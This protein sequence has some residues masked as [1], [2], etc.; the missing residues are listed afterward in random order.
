MALVSSIETVFIFIVSCV[1]S[2][3]ALYC[4]VTAIK[5]FWIHF[6]NR[7]GVFGSDLHMLRYFLQSNKKPYIFV[8]YKIDDSLPWE[9]VILHLKTTLD[10]L[11]AKEN[12]PLGV[13]IDVDKRCWRYQQ[14]GQMDSILEYHTNASDYHSTLDK[15]SRD[16]VFRVYSAGRRIGL[17][18]DHTVFDGILLS[19]Q[20]VQPILG[21][22]PFSNKM[23]MK[24]RY[25]PIISETIQFYALSKLAYHRIRSK[26]L[27]PLI[28][29][30]H[31]VVH[32]SWDM[33]VVK[34]IKR[35]NRCSLIDAMLAAYIEHVFQ[36]LDQSYQTIRTGVVIGFENP[37]FRNNYSVCRVNLNRAC[38]TQ[39]YVQQI[40]KQYKKNQREVLPLYQI[41]ST[42]DLQTRFKSGLID[43][44]FSPLLFFPKDRLSYHLEQT[45]FFNVPCGTPLYVFANAFG[46]RLHCSTTIGTSALDQVGFAGDDGDVFHFTNDYQTVQSP[47]LA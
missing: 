41:F 9:D 1:I 12:S 23:F 27:P 42:H 2:L 20:V 36:H 6:I 40:Q 34:Q 44:L 30:S 43:C 5:R 46:N 3:W 31:S 18:F 38:T 28:Q 10:T 13:S 26:P 25:F 19:Q 4:C 15:L 22:R 32:H 11:L 16:Y 14:P 24:D 35:D 17:L 45:R 21:F 29:Q 7:Q 39:D 37:R 8:D 33:A 47:A